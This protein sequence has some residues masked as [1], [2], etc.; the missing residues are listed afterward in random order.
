M[1]DFLYYM[2]AVSERAA[3]TAGI[4]GP[5]RS[6][7]WRRVPSRPR[8]VKILLFL[9]LL[10][11]AAIAGVAGLLG[12]HFRIFS[13]PAFECEAQ[14]AAEVGDEAGQASLSASSAFSPGEWV[15]RRMRREESAVEKWRRG[16]D[17]IVFFH[18]FQLTS[19]HI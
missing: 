7:W 3:N 1:E 6:W 15:D 14:S 4:K 18:M 2:Y 12:F 17:R 19:M 5:R 8:R 11:G 9:L 13:V 16:R 10:V